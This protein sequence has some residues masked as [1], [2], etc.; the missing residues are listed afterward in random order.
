MEFKEI[1]CHYAE[2]HLHEMFNRLKDEEDVGAIRAH[3]SCLGFIDALYWLNLIDGEKAN[4]FADKLLSMVLEDCLDKT[5]KG[6]FK[7]C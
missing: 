5:I 1:V 6:V 7:K 3:D 2:E 4:D